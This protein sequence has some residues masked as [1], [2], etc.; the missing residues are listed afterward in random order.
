MSK[1]KIL[2]FILLFVLQISVFKAHSQFK[3][4]CAEALE[5]SNLLHEEVHEIYTSAFDLDEQ[6]N[7]F[8]YFWQRNPANRDVLKALVNKV[9]LI[10]IHSNDFMSY[11]TFLQKFVPYGDIDEYE[12]QLIN[13]IFS[14]MFKMRTLIEEN[15]IDTDVLPEQLQSV[16]YSLEIISPQKKIII[17]DIIE[18]ATETL[19]QTHEI[20]FERYYFQQIDL[21]DERINQVNHQGLILT[22]NDYF[23][24]TEQKMRNLGYSDDDITGLDHVMENL[25][26][27]QSLRDRLTDP[28]INP[29]T[30]HIPEFADQIDT[31]INFIEEGIKLQRPSNKAFRLPLLEVFKSEAQS[32]KNSRQVT[33]RWWFNFNLRLSL[34]ASPD[35]EYWEEHEYYKYRLTLDSQWMTNDGLEN[36]YKSYKDETFIGVYFFSAFEN[37]YKFYKDGTVQRMISALDSFPEKIMIPTIHDLR[38]IAINK[39]FGSRTYFVGLNN[40]YAY[41]DDWL[42]N[43]GQFFAHDINHIASSYVEHPQILTRFQFILGNLIRYQREII[44]NDYF[45]ST[46]EVAQ[47]LS[48]YLNIKNAIANDQIDDHIKEKMKENIKEILMITRSQQ[49]YYLQYARGLSKDT[50]ISFY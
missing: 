46:H 20:D 36:V 7:T 33:Y 49:I 45:E 16:I 40:D 4:N 11:N 17:I 35:I 30:L 23:V 34:L 28:S 27:A 1:A 44:E 43:P 37:V 19:E 6:K 38:F 25:R 3:D 14:F 24:E 32:R 41:A 47:N 9:H 13:T 31:H 26:L 15:K 12:Y 5:N 48:Y 18:K 21:I 2:L 8:A 22:D 29:H 39:A 10:H 50:S 42:M